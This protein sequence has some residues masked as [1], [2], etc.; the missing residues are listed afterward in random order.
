MTKIIVR[1]LPLYSMEKIFKET[2][3]VRLSEEAKEELRR[4]LEEKAKEISKKAVE[5]SNHAK[6]NTVLD[7]DIR[8]AI[9]NTK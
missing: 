3:D 2:E 4:Y 9:K 5:F 8:L 7:S 6:R 1:K